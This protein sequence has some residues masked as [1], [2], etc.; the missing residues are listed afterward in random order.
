MK[1]DLI[2]DKF[3]ILNMKKRLLLVKCCEGPTKT[4]KHTF[5]LFLSVCIIGFMSFVFSLH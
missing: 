5:I 2:C 1:K 4:S 3:L